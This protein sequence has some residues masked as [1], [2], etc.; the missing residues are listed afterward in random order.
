MHFA[1]SAGLLASVMLAT[2]LSAQW[3][4]PGPPRG[5]GRDELGAIQGRIIADGG[6]RKDLRVLLVD[7]SG[8]ET[9]AAEVS[10]AGTFSFSG[11]PHGSY[12]LRLL[13]GGAPLSEQSVS[14]DGFADAVDLRLPDRAKSASGTTVSVSDF[15]QKPP[16]AALK[17]AEKGESAMH[18]AQ[19]SYCTPLSESSLIDLAAR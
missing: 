13:Q 4:A 8:A 1:G 7:Q 11:I 18:K 15:L 9:A 19:A 16:A 17:V 14:V 12:T 3:A 5:P 10:L 6:D 2:S